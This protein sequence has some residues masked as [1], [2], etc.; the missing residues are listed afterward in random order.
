MIQKIISGGQTGVDRAGLDAAM[1]LGLPA[2]GW[3]PAGR[4][5]E[6]GVIP[7]KYPLTETDTDDYEIRTEL[8]VKDSDATLI[9]NLGP[10][11]GGTAFTVEMAKRHGKPYLVVQMDFT[12]SVP[13]VGDWL[14]EVSPTTLNIAGP[15]ESGRLGIHDAAYDFMLELCEWISC[16]PV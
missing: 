12:P 3:C 14:N 13:G 16:N 4:L 9:L 10:L 7:E 1:H 11:E 5:A 2:G 6:D 8:N 15:R